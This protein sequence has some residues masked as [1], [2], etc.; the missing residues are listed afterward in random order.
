MSAKDDISMYSSFVINALWKSVCPNLNPKY[1][2]S[3]LIKNEL[4]LL[5]KTYVAALLKD[6]KDDELATEIETLMLKRVCKKFKPF[7]NQNV[8]DSNPNNLFLKSINNCM[9]EARYRIKQRFDYDQDEKTIDK[10]IPPARFYATLY[11]MDPWLETH[12][13]YQHLSWIT[14]GF[15]KN[16]DE[17]FNFFKKEYD[18]R[19]FRIYIT[20]ESDKN[21]G[22]T[23][24]QIE[25]I[26]YSQ[27]YVSE[28][29]NLENF[30]DM[31]QH[32]ITAIVIYYPNREDFKTAEAERE[33]KRQ[34]T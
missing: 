32:T 29:S 30:V 22:W 10:Q 17:L 12:K 27:N 14:V 23:N 24:E 7:D 13:T 26:E 8:D 9:Y 25:R 21:H 5:I 3:D 28:Y 16:T 6:P 19:T 18:N 20:N 34:K 33:A 1:L 11:R 31:N 15:P 4:S 2:N